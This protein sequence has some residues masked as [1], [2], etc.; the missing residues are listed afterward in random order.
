V[1]AVDA[2]DL[3][4]PRRP[5]T[6]VSNPPFAVTTALLKRLVAPGSRLHAA[7]VIV[8]RHIARQ[9]CAHGVDGSIRWGGV[10][11]VTVGL[12][13]PAHAFTPAAPRDAV[14]LRI[15]RLDG[16]QPDPSRGRRKGP[17]AR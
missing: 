9:W 4:L 8:P 14:V 7:D 11:E 16:R 10:F 5:F 3:R 6:V 17:P 15:R 2:A 1:V 13:L 12:R